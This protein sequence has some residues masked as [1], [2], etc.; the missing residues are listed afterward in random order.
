MGGAANRPG[1]QLALAARGA[2]CI[3]RSYY[4]VRFWGQIQGADLSCASFF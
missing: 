4:W 1:R 3:T 2:V